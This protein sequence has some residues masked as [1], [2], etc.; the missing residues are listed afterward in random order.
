MTKHWGTIVEIARKNGEYHSVGQVFG[1]TFLCKRKIGKHMFRGGF[2]T[3]EEAI[4]AGK[5]CWAL[6]KEILVSL[7]EK[8]AV[9]YVYI[10][11]GKEVYATT[12]SNFLTYGKLLSFDGDRDQ[13]SLNL[14]YFTVHKVLDHDEKGYP[15]LWPPFVKE[16]QNN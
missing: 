15:E 4:Q 9:S 10:L 7:K 3:P 13:M 8:V 2:S 1:D 16:G 5:A 14:R 6:D 11:V 12:V